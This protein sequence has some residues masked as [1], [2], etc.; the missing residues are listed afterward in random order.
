M[1]VVITTSSFAEYD[2]RPLEL[3]SENSCEFI[4]NPFKRKITTEEAIALYRDADGVVAGTENIDRRVLEQAPR[5]KVISRCGTAIDNIDID[6]ARSKGI[7]VFNTPDAATEAV[8]ELTLGLILSLLR[9]MAHADRQMH[10]GI[11]EKNMGYLLHQKTVGIIGFG[12]IG[13]RTAALLR[14]FG[15]QILYSDPK[16]KDDNLDDCKNVNFE[17]LLRNS[18]IVILHMSYSPENKHYIG[19]KQIALMKKEAFLVNVSRGEVIDEE[20]LY[21]ALK[22]G[23][24][25][26][27]A[28]DVFEKEP[29]NGV[30]KELHNVVLTPHIGSYAKESR[31]EMEME[32]VKNL[33]SGLKG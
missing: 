4:L 18:D 17:E 28:L 3:L 21:N 7:K 6:F 29:Y 13:R 1:R 24:I 32:A 14:S 15:V 33:L 31:V 30:L 10:N 22:K 20:A 25:A 19:K 5:L 16:I 2:K 12:R 27:A 26:G 8:S 9:N 11:W 23:Q